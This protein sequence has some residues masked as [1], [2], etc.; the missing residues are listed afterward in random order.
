MAVYRKK[1]IPSIV[2]HL[3]VQPAVTGTSSQ[4]SQVRAAGCHGYEHGC[5]GCEQPAV[6]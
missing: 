4:L 2:D 5:H 1:L 6:T 3:C